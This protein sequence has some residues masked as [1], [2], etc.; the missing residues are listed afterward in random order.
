MNLKEAE[1]MV[2]KL[3]PE[4]SSTVS[5]NFD[6]FANLLLDDYD[7]WARDTLECI[8]EPSE[9]EFEDTFEAWKLV[10]ERYFKAMCRPVPSFKTA[11]GVT[12]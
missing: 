3:L 9:D 10:A 12:C 8:L 6:G 1:A 5:S 7:D 11:D 2:E 4:W